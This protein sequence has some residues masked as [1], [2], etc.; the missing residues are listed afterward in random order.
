MIKN[1]FH[2]HILHGIDDGA[3][4][5]EESLA[6]LEIL[7]NS[8]VENLVLS[9]HFYCGNT[10]MEKMLAER[11]TAFDQLKREY[12]GGISL[13]LGAEVGVNTKYNKFSS[14]KKLAINGGQYLLLEL[15][16]QKDWKNLG[17]WMID[18]MEETD[19]V[20]IIA[21]V[22]YYEQ[23]LAKP[24]IVSDFID[25]GCK[26]QVN[27]TSFLD[28]GLESLVLKLVETGHV[29][30]IGSDAHNLGRRPP[31]IAECGK[32]IESVFGHGAI[33]KINNSSDKILEGKTFNSRYTK[34]VKKFFGKYK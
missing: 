29:Q 9:P 23:V 20:P 19:L 12:K 34:S 28:K 21:H 32:K 17:S 31:K 22:E 4:T 5:I 1:D 11:E 7:E 8:G 13:N 24:Q 3:K 27:A 16:F 15:P 14:L 30:C 26:V 18:L 2:S 6:M 25:M 33:D 10:D